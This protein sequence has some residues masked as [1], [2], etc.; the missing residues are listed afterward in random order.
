MQSSYAYIYDE[1]LND[2]KYDRELMKFEA[3]ISTRGLQGRIGKFAMFRHAKDIVADITRDEP[4]TLVVVGDETTL[5]TVISSLGT[6]NIVLGFIPLLGEGLISKSCAIPKGMAAI[7]V[8]AGRFI[9]EVDVG[10]VDK[11]LFLK[12][13]VIQGQ[14]VS[15]QIDDRFKIETVQEGQMIIRNIGQHAEAGDGLLDLLLIG[16]KEKKRFPWSRKP[17]TET[18]HLR[19]KKAVL[20]RSLQGSCVVDGNP[21]NGERLELSLQPKALRIISG[22][23]G[24]MTLAESKAV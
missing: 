13:I 4:H 6:T 1:R 5:L 22:R 8:L 14:G 11:R 15:L 19:F 12:E 17:K 7:H 20:Y 23:R 24:R 21:I 10:M 9:E 2:R 16:T 3:E 18:T